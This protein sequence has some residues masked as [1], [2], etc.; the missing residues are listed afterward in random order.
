MAPKYLSVSNKGFSLLEVLIAVLVIAFG[1]LGMA[2][3][4]LKT[5]QNSHSAYQRT[6]ASII[7]MDAAERLWINLA[8]NQNIDT[9]VKPSWR[10]SSAGLLSFDDIQNDLNFICT[11]QNSCTITVSWSEKRL[12]DV[13]NQKST[14]VYTIDL[15]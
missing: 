6:V 14:F 8:L 12:A 10:N 7:A 4:Q 2:A 9:V 15:Y 3:L 1:L 11:V 5:V 13:A